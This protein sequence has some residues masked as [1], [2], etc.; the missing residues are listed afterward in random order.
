[1]L[2]IYTEFVTEGRPIIAVELIQFTI[3]LL[4]HVATIVVFGLLQS[5]VVKPGISCILKHYT[6]AMYVY[7]NVVKFVCTYVCSLVII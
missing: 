6:V 1:M 7:Y 4:A 5:V 3:E 2:F